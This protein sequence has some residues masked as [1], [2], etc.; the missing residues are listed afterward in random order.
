MLGKPV[1]EKG[2]TR[3]GGLIHP[4][5]IRMVNPGF[6]RTFH[7]DEDLRFSGFSTKESVERVDLFIEAKHRAVAKGVPSRSSFP[8]SR[9][10]RAHHRLPP[11]WERRA[12]RLAL[13]RPLRHRRP[14]NPKRHPWRSS[15]RKDK[16]RAEPSNTSCGR[17]AP[18]SG[19]V[20]PVFRVRIFDITR[21]ASKRRRLTRAGWRPP[22]PRHVGCLSF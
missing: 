3:I 5:C 16:K 19:L 9:M 4:P 2:A 10:G 22:T 6:W 8:A 17:F 13:G 18:G 20:Q 15:P 12:R 21:R 7:G 1:Q 14:P 11:M